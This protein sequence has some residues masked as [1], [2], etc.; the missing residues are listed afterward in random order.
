MEN[1]ERKA[2]MF[3]LN[4][5]EQIGE[6]DDQELRRFIVNLI[7]YHEGKKIVLETKVDRIM[8]QGIQTALKINDEK[9][10]N[11]A[12]ANRENGKSGGRPPKTKNDENPSIP[13]GFCQNPNNLITDKREEE[14]DKRKLEIENREKLNVE[15]KVL[16]ENVVKDNLFDGPNSGSLIK[17]PLSIDNSK[18]SGGISIAEFNRR[19][20]GNN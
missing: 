10:L 2:F 13:D 8:W 6:L 17:T 20:A 14:I 18:N 3:Y 9:Y 4:W 16:N 19:K 11:K 1:I 12:A 15:R 7:N 5:Q